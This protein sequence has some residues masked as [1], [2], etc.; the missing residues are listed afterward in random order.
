MIWVID[1]SVAVRWFLSDEVDATA[2]S[3]LE[4]LVSEPGRFAVPE[5]F[6]F[7]TFAVLQR[8]H[9]EPIA[10]FLDGITPILQG[11]LLRYPMTPSIARRADRFVRAGLTGY[12]ATYVGLAEELGGQWITYDKKAFHALNDSQLARL[13]S[14]DSPE[15]WGSTS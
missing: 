13:L 14:E 4:H 2:Y 12:D 10:A 5:L 3:V 15:N 11:G 1:A 8:L 6:C 9:P 7:E